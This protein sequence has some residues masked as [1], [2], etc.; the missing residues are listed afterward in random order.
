MTQI[1]HRMVGLVL[2]I[3]LV[4]G[5]PGLAQSSADEESGALQGPSPG[6][7]NNPGAQPPAE[8]YRHPSLPTV[9]PP[10]SGKERPAWRFDGGV[11]LV[12]PDRQRSLHTQGGSTSSGSDDPRM[13]IR[14]YGALRQ[15]WGGDV[16]QGVKYAALLV[17]TNLYR[18]RYPLKDGDVAEISVGKEYGAD[19]VFHLTPRLGLVGGVGLIDSYSVG[20]IEIPRASFRRAS[21]QITS[22]GLRAVPVRFGAQY[23]IPLGRRRSLIVD[24]GAGLY[25]T[26]LQWSDRAEVYEFQRI[27]HLR[28][29]TSG[30]GFGLH[31]GV[32][33]DIGLSD[34]MGLV[35]GVQGVHANIGG[36]EGFREGTYTYIPAGTRDD[37]TL[38]IVEFLYEPEWSTLVVGEGT[39]TMDRYG[40]FGAKKEAR[41]G[42]GGL[43]YTGGLRVSF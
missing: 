39:R 22:L 24:G 23:A 32:S 15:L 18:G 14:V 4:T 3:G 41:V 33:L 29:E 43:R 19:L 16:N 13:S 35:V 12:S 25:F 28:S 20:Q 42:L 17:A 34:R 1:A 30:S 27:T 9:E 7:D 6:I 37:G 40:P 31:G 38:Q 11:S 8:G 26:R 10:F 21:G 5:S 36:L 2:G